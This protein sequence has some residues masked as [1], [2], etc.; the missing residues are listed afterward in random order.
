MVCFSTTFLSLS[1]EQCSGTAN[2][3]STRV[4]TEAFLKHQMELLSSG[5]MDR[6]LSTYILSD[7]DQPFVPYPGSMG[8]PRTQ[9]WGSPQR[10]QLQQLT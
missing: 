3:D 9:V 1:P 5:N 8:K 7:L 2:A 4:K 6:F 10:S